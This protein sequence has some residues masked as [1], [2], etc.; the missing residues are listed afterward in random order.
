MDQAWQEC[1]ISLLVLCSIVQ[2]LVC[3][4]QVLVCL[5]QV[6]VCVLQ[7]LVCVLQVLICVLQDIDD[8]YQKERDWACN[9]AVYMRQ[10]VQNYNQM[11]NAMSRKFVLYIVM[12]V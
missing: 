12:A 9:H 1:D 3:L 5:L 4:L 2:I 11:V 10:A 7:V 8:Y 6:L